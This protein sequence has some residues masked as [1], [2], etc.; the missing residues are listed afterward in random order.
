MLARHRILFS[1]LAGV[2]LVAS[3]FVPAQ[4]ATK[5]ESD[6]LGDA[7][8]R[9]DVTH[10]KYSNLKHKLSS[11]VR[12]KDLRRS[13]EVDLWLSGTGSGATKFA[14]VWVNKNDRLVKRFYDFTDDQLTRQK[15][16][17]SARWRAA[18]NLVRVSV[19]K[20]C[21]GSGSKKSVSFQAQTFAANGR[22]DSTKVVRVTRG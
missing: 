20:T 14:R 6:P 21:M 9:I 2:A 4:A 10:V 15:C 13:G 19:P 17:V 12:I 18:D 11:L 8:A 1:V 3:T 7:P 5:G 16:A 22:S